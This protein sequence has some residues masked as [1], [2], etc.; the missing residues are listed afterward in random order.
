M[1]YAKRFN[2]IKEHF[3]DFI[4]VGKEK[5]SAVNRTHQKSYISF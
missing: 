1:K 3:F 2:G 5:Q 4:P